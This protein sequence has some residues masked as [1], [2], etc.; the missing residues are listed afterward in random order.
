MSIFSYICASWLCRICHVMG[1]SLHFKIWTWNWSNKCL[2]SLKLKY[3]KDNDAPQKLFRERIKKIHVTL[4]ILKNVFETLIKHFFPQIYNVG[5][6]QIISPF[7][8]SVNQCLFTI[9]NFVFLNIT[10]FMNIP[11]I[12]MFDIYC[13]LPFII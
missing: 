13:F 6:I 8:F 7:P 1:I 9:Y 11:F 2:F 3:Y 4:Y 5:N 10:F 12:K